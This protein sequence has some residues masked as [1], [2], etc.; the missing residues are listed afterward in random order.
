[1]VVSLCVPCTPRLMSSL[2]FFL[3][4]HLFLVSA[5]FRCVFALAPFQFLTLHSICFDFA[6]V[7]MCV[8]GVLLV[9]QLCAHVHLHYL[10]H[11]PTPTTHT[12]TQFF[13][14][15]FILFLSS[16]FFPFH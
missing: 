7:E 12:H 13:S 5:P 11:L 8:A 4:V 3:T 10:I 9:L 16:P 1:M 14:K 6:V 2:A 15:N